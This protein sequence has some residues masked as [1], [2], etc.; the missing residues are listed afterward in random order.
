MVIGVKVRGKTSPPISNCEH[1][2]KVI[3][4]ISMISD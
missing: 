1:M 4:A 3:C 2:S